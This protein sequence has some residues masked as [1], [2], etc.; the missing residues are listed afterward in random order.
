MLLLLADEYRQPVP[1]LRSNP[2][3]LTMGF[4]EA[5]PRQLA[6]S[7]GT[8]QVGITISAVPPSADQDSRTRTRSSPL[9]EFKITTSISIIS[10]RS[11][12]LQPNQ[13]RHPDN[14]QIHHQ[15]KKNSTTQKANAR[16][17]LGNTTRRVAA[18]NRR[19]THQSTTHRRP[20]SHHTPR[21]RLRN[22]DR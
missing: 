11:S 15:Q 22:S 21:Q 3:S 6:P 10:S 18:C 7:V 16:T 2:G 20:D 12:S 14:H 5:D 8:T 9:E 19:L 1:S 13:I 17:L 4:A